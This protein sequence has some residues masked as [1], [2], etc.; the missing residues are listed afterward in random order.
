MA[1]RFSHE[2]EKRAISGR[3]EDATRIYQDRFEE[4]RLRPTMKASHFG[5][6]VNESLSY[7]LFL[8]TVESV[9]VKSRIVV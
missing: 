6:N 7:L 8:E 3:A 1:V 9:V 5:A 4:K 2:K